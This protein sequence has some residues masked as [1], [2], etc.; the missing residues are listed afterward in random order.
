MVVGSVL[1]EGSGMPKV[2]ELI[3]ETDLEEPSL[4]L[5]FKAAADLS[6]QN[7]V[8][9]KVTVGRLLETRG[10]LQQA[11]GLSEIY[12]LS[13][14]G[15]D[16]YLLDAP[17][18]VYARIVKESSAKAKVSRT[19][20][21]ELPSLKD[22]SG[23][24]TVDVVAGIQNALNEQLLS[25][26]DNTTISDLSDTF[27]EYL[28]LLERRKEVAEE[29][30]NSQGLQ[31]IPSLLPGLNRITGGWRAGQMITVAAGTSIGKSV[32]AINCAVA[33][34]RANATTMVFSLE[35]SREE[36]EDRVISST[37]AIP[38][39]K[40]KQ[41]E[42]TADELS[43]LKDQ[44]EAMRSM[45]LIMD[46]EPLI[47]VDE[48]RAK[49]LRQAQSP[50]G[51]DFV[52]IDYLQLIQ[53]KGRH[54]SRQEA[55]ADI[56]RNIKLMAK[57]LGV[58]VMALAQLNRDKDEEDSLPTLEKIRESHAIA[59]DSDI[60]ILLH[61]KQAADDGIV[62]PTLVIVD[63]NRNGENKKI[64][65]C[66]SNLECSVFLEIVRK[67]DVEKR[68][69]ADDEEAAAG[70]LDLDAFDSDL[71]GDDDILEF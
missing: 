30:K 31:G 39:K 67:D 22:N 36:I 41:G 24:R 42:L 49:A 32:F 48:I 4:E 27:G 2:L 8:I 71:D 62:P 12:A 55:V 37:T 25:L 3:N 54:G 17:V 46:T 65:P 9:S 34:A 52:I 5:I 7:E 57:Q 18:E 68:L 13:A 33:A 20:T 43:T 16:R 10:E 45:R 19:L 29:N 44:M 51:L 66:H 14:E 69:T 1:A 40:L 47:S 58:P 38:L 11:G 60:V 61:R 53:A 70:D 64:I 28:E 21:E 63:K 6:R 50:E 26:S 35:M 56:S 59:Q 23:K 15:R